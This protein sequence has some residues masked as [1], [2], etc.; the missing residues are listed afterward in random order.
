MSN[1][2]LFGLDNKVGDIVVIYL[3]SGKDIQGEVLEICDKYILIKKDDG[4][5][6]RLFE[7]IVGAWETIESKQQEEDSKS[8]EEIPTKTLAET[9]AVDAPSTAVCHSQ[10]PTT[11]PILDNNPS[12]SDSQTSS[13]KLPGIKIVGKIDLSQFSKPSAKKTEDKRS[14]VEPAPT[15]IEQN[16][17]QITP[18]QEEHSIVEKFKNIFELLKINLD[19]KIHTNAKVITNQQGF[20]GVGELD[21]GQTVEIK[22]EGFVGNEQ[23]LCCEGIRLF[24]RPNTSRTPIV[25]NVT[26]QEV[27][28]KEIISFFSAFVNDKD[29][30]KAITIIKSLR[31]FPIFAPADAE[32]KEIYE[33]I[34]I[35]NRRE[36]LKNIVDIIIPTLEEESRIQSFMSSLI[37]SEDKEHPLQDIQIRNAYTFKY[38]TRIPVDVFQS[39]RE[40]YGI[41]SPEL[42]SQTVD[43]VDDEDDVDDMGHDEEL[44][45]FDATLNIQPDPEL[46]SSISED[47][48]DKFND[49]LDRQALE[50][51]DKT[52][53]NGTIISQDN[54]SLTIRLDNGNTLVANAAA[55]FPMQLRSLRQVGSRVFCPINNQVVTKC[56]Y[57]L[58]EITYSH[59][60]Q[61]F[62]TSI[63]YFNYTQANRL[64]K[65][66]SKFALLTIYHPEFSVLNTLVSRLKSIKIC[67]DVEKS[68]STG[69][70][71]R[72]R[73]YVNRYVSEHLYEKLTAYDLKVKIAT[74]LG[75]KVKGA[76]LHYL[77]TQSMQ[78]LTNLPSDDTC[79]YIKEYDIFKQNLESLNNRFDID[80]ETLL[81]HLDSISMDLEDKFDISDKPNAFVIKVGRNSCT[82][83]YNS[84]NIRCYYNSVLDFNLLKKMSEFKEGSLPVRVLTFVKKKT[85]ETSISNIVDVL[86]IRDHISNLIK[87]V[88]D[89]NF[90]Y[91]RRYNQNIQSFI[92]QHLSS[93]GNTHLSRVIKILKNASH[94]IS[95]LP[96]VAINYSVKIQAEQDASKRE[97]QNISAKSDSLLALGKTDEAINLISATIESGKLLSQDQGVLYQKLIQIY[98]SADRQEEA[99]K[100][101]TQWISYGEQQNMFT[102]K[103]LSRLYTDLA[104]LQYSI[105]EQ[106]SDALESLQKALEYNPDNRLSLNLQEQIKSAILERENSNGATLELSQ[107]SRISH[108]LDVISDMLDLDIRE[109]KYADKRIVAAGSPT[110]EIANM[111]LEEAKSA[112]L[113]ES[114]PLFL[115]TAKAFHDL[116]FYNNQDYIYIVANYA[117]QKG[118]FL[119]NT[120]RKNILSHNSQGSV[121]NKYLCRLKDSAQSYYLESLNLWSYISYEEDDDTE[122]NTSNSINQETIVL[123]ALLN[124][125]ILDVVYYLTTDNHK[126]P[127]TFNDLFNMQ[128]K[129]VF[130]LCLRSNEEYLHGVAASTIVK[131]GSYSSTVWNKLASIPN[132]TSGLYGEL[133]NLDKRKRFYESI[134]KFESASISSDL[135][136]KEFLQ[137]AFAQHSSERYEFAKLISRL[138]EEAL[139]PHGMDILASKWNDLLPFR[140][141]LSETDLVSSGKVESILTILK[142]YPHRNDDERSTLLYQVTEIIDEQISFINTNTTYYG[143]TFFYPLLTKWAGEIRNIRKERVASKHPKLSIAPDPSYI[144]VKEGKQVVNLIIKN[145]GETT[146]EGF[147]LEV[148]Y[149]S[150]HNEQISKRSVELFTEIP[151][152]QISA[153][154]LIIDEKIEISSG[155][156][157]RAKIAPIYQ[158]NRLPFVESEFT[159]EEEPESLLEMEDIIWSD[160]PITPRKLFFGRQELI[161]K[162]EKHYLSTNK[163]KP[164]ILYG[165]TRT[166]KSSIVK[167]LG[168]QITGNQIRVQGE[169]K[170][171]LH[172]SMDLD[173]AAKCPNAKEVWEFFIKRCLYKQ[174]CEY[175]LHYPIDVEYFA[176][177]DHPK[178]YE[179]EDILKKLKEKGYYPFITMDEF[180]HMKTLIKNGKLTSAFLHTLR[181]YAFDG[182]ASF[183]YIGTYDIN[184]LLSNKEYG[185]TGQFTHCINYQLNE[186]DEK[187]AKELI[188]VLGEKL[189]FTEDAQDYICKLSGRVPYFIQIICQNCGK[190]AVETRRRYIGYPE[191]L[192]VVK[193]LTGESEI[194]DDDTELQRLTINTFE[195]NQYSSNDPDFVLALI[196]SISYLNRECDQNNV[197]PKGIRIDELERLWI[198]YGIKNAKYYIGKAITI[199][200]AKK[201]IEQNNDEL[202]PTYSIIVDL[203]RRWCK[204]EYPDINL[205]LSPLLNQDN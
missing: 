70:L 57:C 126:I 67:I 37:Q 10:E 13:V 133:R 18:A 56:K 17:S 145:F 106:E 132:G 117:R 198:D 25:S 158:A 121:D 128:F 2:E 147:Y 97:A 9:P 197:P 22:K 54:V 202:I 28:Y 109:H 7:N 180:S 122:L 154:A 130:Y 8:A 171:I 68:L 136:P 14:E 159:L 39:I 112:N 118:N 101:Y 103:K 131:L 102:V 76:Y 161:N 164:Y 163:H 143:R 138:K 195:D 123:E 38:K 168:L 11:N 192:D 91:A 30:V 100:V 140:R 86:S 149:Y 4:K 16:D 151:A 35:K 189:I 83:N 146:A 1:L 196:A 79:P 104:R 179:F 94:D 137:I 152:G 148:E 153:Y 178:S 73:E 141:L 110:I 96:I 170:T 85:G 134:N 177:K 21:S 162:L 184:D 60:K 84:E 119:F 50:P 183:M 200:K 95:E 90:A 52:P 172:F 129:D 92:S 59:L 36:E 34:K 201:I 176:P 27:T 156:N 193:Y 205:M 81:Y 175:A 93:S 15:K 48:I 173:D 6:M 72:I 69:E 194:Y 111:L 63:R 66:A 89:D 40:K 24:C 142:P 186:I 31:S 124:H 87:L 58:L 182:L 155:V 42:R 190:Y 12:V 120:F 113:V 62:E 43:T 157:V 165:L 98:T 188:N 47:V 181:K 80:K 199:L 82:V 74:D 127:Q 105:P 78:K 65:I 33:T 55:L 5:T 20:Y 125:M 23:L 26:I 107:E 71:N 44:N 160:G 45:I 3:N 29:F 191:L 32:L 139:S 115:E 144:L 169:L 46:F 166:G 185:I 187:S 167:Y 19:S 51:A 114:Y 150:H 75:L 203:Y 116:K 99:I 135:S 88:E 108:S 61:A 41:P 49:I 53:S 64:I 77:L 204:V 174:I